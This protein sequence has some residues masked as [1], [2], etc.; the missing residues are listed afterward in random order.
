MR[1]AILSAIVAASSCAHRAPHPIA[2]GHLAAAVAYLDEGACEQAEERCR[3]ALEFGDDFPEAHNC[4]GIVALDCKNDV[5]GAKAHFEKAL[6]QNEDLAQA[7]NNL[8]SCF[9]RGS[10]PDEA[11]A[12]EE[13][14]AAL[15]IDP[16][17]LDARENLAACLVRRG[18]VRG[19]RG[20]REGRAE[21]FQEARSQLI[22]LLEIRPNHHR[23]HAYLGLMAVIDLRLAEA[24]QRFRSCLEIRPADA[25]CHYDLG[26]AFLAE[27]DC[28]SAMRELASALRAPD[29][30]DAAPD[31]QRDYAIAY[32][33]CAKRDKATLAELERMKHAPPSAENHA[34]LARIYASRGLVAEAAAEWRE[35]VRLDPNE[36]AAHFEIAEHAYRTLDSAETVA[37]CRRFL[38]CAGGRPESELGPRGRPG[39]VERC[40]AW[41]ERIAIE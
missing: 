8:G 1:I 16:G 10:P 13:F 15:E 25:V 6:S 35:T 36:C 12:S 38:A 30:A 7:H 17:Y 26:I 40:R 24:K 39:A 11:R 29:A 33:L 19:D 4:L 3:L 28:E 22:R 20:D 34:A 5:A 32:D 2:V 37:S 9:L 21:L 14:E 18:I 31:I 23:A 41:L 27:S